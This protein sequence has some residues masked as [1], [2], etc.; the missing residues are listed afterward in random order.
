[1]KKEYVMTTIHVLDFED[2]AIM[3]SHNS[4][5]HEDIKLHIESWQLIFY[6]HT[7]LFS[8]AEYNIQGFTDG[9]VVIVIPLVKVKPTE[10]ERLRLNCKKQ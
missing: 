4:R 5:K 2:A 8:K 9:V 3:K 1:M 7:L 10:Y 6:F